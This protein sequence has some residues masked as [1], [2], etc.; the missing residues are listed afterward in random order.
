MAATPTPAAGP[1]TV[2]PAAG[3]ARASTAARPKEALVAQGGQYWGVYLAS[4]AAADDAAVGSAYRRLQGMG[5]L[6]STGGLCDDGDLASI[7]I[8]QGDGV[9]SVYFGSR[10]EALQFID[11]WK[12]PYRGYAQVRTYCAD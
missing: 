8:N 10:A 7:G 5:Y 4:S 2:A 11:L 6:G 3:P 9:T 12:A 1:A